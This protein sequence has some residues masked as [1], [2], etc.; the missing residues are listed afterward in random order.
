M[1]SSLFELKTTLL[2]GKQSESLRCKAK[3]S[4]H[5]ARQSDAMKIPPRYID[6]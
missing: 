1:V 6:G 3:D 4:R 2:M 5:Y